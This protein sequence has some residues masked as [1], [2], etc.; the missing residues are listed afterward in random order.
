MPLSCGKRS[1]TP[2][3]QDSAHGQAAG[4]HGTSQ[5]D[6]EIQK[7]T[8]DELVAKMEKL[9]SGQLFDLMKKLSS[10]QRRA[11]M[12][13]LSPEQR[14]ALIGK[15]TPEQRQALMAMRSG[16][17][18]G[19]PGG[20]QGQ[21]QAPQQGDQRL[22]SDQRQGG[23]L[24]P[25]EVS[26]VMRRDMTD[27]ILAS[28]SIE[29]LREIEIYAKTTGIATDLK[30]EEGDI[31]KA[32]NVLIILDDRE[33]KLSLR[34]REIE[35]QE[36]ENALKRSKEMMSRNLISQEEFETAQL[37]F[38]SA[39]TSFK[40]AKLTLEYTSVTAPISGTITERFVE[41]GTMVT[42]GKALFRLADFDPL[43][44]RIFIPERELRRLRV[45]QE[46]LLSID[47]EPDRE[48]PAIVELISSVIDP[49]SG[50]FKVT[51]E[52]GDAGGFLRPGMFASA[53]IIVDEHPDT[54]AVRAEA[55]LYEGR[56][57]YI[58]VVRDGVAARVDVKAGFT[59]E[60]YVEVS[61]PL[62]E[63][64]M[65]VIAGQNNL[66]DGTKVDVVK[67]VSE[68]K[69]EGKEDFAGGNH[70]AFPDPEP[71]AKSEHKDNRYNRG[72][73][74]DSAGRGN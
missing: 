26:M 41:L 18:G 66:A 33:A 29:A 72:S 71:K 43:R 50:T 58:Y 45:G 38:E 23:A 14:V 24:I 52:I 19:P 35:F 20:Q 1:E 61:G 67:G 10:E 3:K 59:D 73:P 40:E 12:E 16:G 69:R 30:V 68:G 11:V 32:G 15:L 39:L 74:P 27:Y 34:R 8:T 46:V 55:I 2:E 53:K 62:R 63:G 37:S 42:T 56:Q 57:R 60:G 49:S 36:A 51:V 5:D 44:A 25:V 48:F 54:P 17:P 70:G 47:S 31:V 6:S 13:N 22:M 21:H 28:T 65:V 4:Q 9:D 7:M 64:E